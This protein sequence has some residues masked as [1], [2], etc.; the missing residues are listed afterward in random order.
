MKCFHCGQEI[1]QERLRYGIEL[2][3]LKTRILDAVK[4]AGDDGIGGHDLFDLFLRERGVGRD[5]LKCHVYQIN[6]KL[7]GT[8]YRID[9]TRNVDGHEG[10]YRMCRKRE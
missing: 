4:R 5:V 8:D 3:P 9:V 6:E 2:S 7:A 1:P 10:V